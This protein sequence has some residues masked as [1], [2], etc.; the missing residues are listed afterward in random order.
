MSPLATSPLK[1]LVALLESP[2]MQPEPWCQDAGLTCTSNHGFWG[3][4]EK[5]KYLFLPH[6][7]SARRSPRCLADANQNHREASRRLSNG[8]G[9]AN[10][11]GMSIKVI[12]AVGMPYS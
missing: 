3:P 9:S 12:G 8:F 4:Q 11:V 5:D 1:G 2:A 10:A 7:A 6:K